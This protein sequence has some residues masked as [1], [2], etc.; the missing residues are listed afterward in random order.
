MRLLALEL[1]S[2]KAIQELFEKA[3]NLGV[4]YAL[5]FGLLFACGLGLPLPED[6]PLIISG[7]MVAQGKMNLALAA[8]L[9][10]CG[11]IGGDVLLYRFGRKYGRN[12]TKVPFI[13]RHVT[14]ARIEHAERLF[15]RYGIWVV[16][17]GRLFAGIRGAMV[18][19]AGTIRYNFV[20][21]II[22]DS[23]A[24]IV[25]G[26]MFIAIGYY[27]GSKLDVIVPKIKKWEN[28]ILWIIV[29]V[30]VGFIV[31]VWWRK[32]RRAPIVDMALEKA[33]KVAASHPPKESSRT[34]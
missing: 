27:L 2:L 28:A 22:A 17:I 9:A 13:G 1:I 12:I 10:W 11:I 15:E 29:T 14:E 33:D 6:I 34:I 19:A 18:V 25:S 7:A 30:V 32:R 31:W 26:G 8:F 23:L 16:A 5:L 3:N 4:G 24:A 20:K 21:F